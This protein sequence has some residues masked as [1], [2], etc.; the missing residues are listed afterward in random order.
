M[1]RLDK[2]T[3]QDFLAENTTRRPDAD[4]VVGIDTGGT[5]TDGVL[6]DYST[7][8]VLASAKTLTTYGDLTQGIISVLQELKIESPHQVKLV[9]ISSTLATNSIA[10]GN[11]KP[12]GL[13]LIGYDQDLLQNYGLEAKFSTGRFA[14][15]QGGHNAQGEQKAPLDLQALK[16]WVQENSPNMEALAIS[17]Y[18]S[19]LNPEHE[20]QALE[21]LREITDLPVVLGHQLSTQLDS[22]KRA[23]TASL[24]ASLVAVMHEFIQAVKKS[25][26]DLGFK[27]PLMIVKGD[28]SLMPYTEAAQ[29]PVETVLSGPAASTIGGR[30]LSGRNNALVI[31]VGGTTTDMALIEEGNI[32]VTDQGARVGNI[33]T[34]VQAAR[35]RTVCLGCDSRVSIPSAKEFQVGPNRVV[36][37]SRLAASHPQVAEELLQVENRRRTGRSETDIEY[38]FLARDH[39]YLQQ[40]DF[41]PK[42]RALLDLLQEEPLSMH[43]VLQKM[44]VNHPVQLGLEELLQ[45]GH[46]GLAGLTPT[47]LLHFKGELDIGHSQAAT[48]ALK[49]ICR[50]HG[51]KPG[52]MADRILEHIISRMTEEAVIFL[53]RQNELQLPE[54]LDGVWSRWLYQQALGADNP[55]L[56]VTIEARFPIIGIGAPAEIF[57][58]KVAAKLHSRFELPEYPHVANAV[59]AVAGSVIVDK[60]ALVFVQESEEERAF[61][62]QFEKQKKSFP[63]LQEALDYARH[64]AGRAAREAAEDA[65][66]EQPQ[67]QIRQKTEGALQRIK[68]RAVGNPRLAE[69][70]G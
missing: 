34:A 41:G 69:Q 31:D 59:G 47:D 15:F 5:Y 39:D 55:H 63:E 10:E 17:S 46:I 26:K 1:A 44:Q 8:R 3:P 18:F 56:S 45:K 6:L 67:V 64:Q 58:R 14:Y 19:P 50:L 36:P 48:Q 24:N 49:F 25:L 21:A 61:I 20:E 12:V 4:Y 62:V 65:G 29:K 35:I 2:K 51:L 43:D 38:L 68:A 42:H 54:D 33:E 28:G 66:A 57:V 11:I 52:E 23:T 27:A 9:G 37:L 7:R 70:F 32:A 30:F 13:A 60:E 16:A 40:Q 53:A 22:V